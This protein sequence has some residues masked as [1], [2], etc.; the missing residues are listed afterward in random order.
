MI[1]LYFLNDHKLY[2]EFVFE[3]YWTSKTLK[4]IANNGYIMPDAERRNF[5]TIVFVGVNLP[6]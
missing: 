6:D 3:Q 4:E 5:G 1:F 2:L